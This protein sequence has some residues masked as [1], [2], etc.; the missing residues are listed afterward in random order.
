[1]LADEKRTLGNEY[2]TA[3]CHCKQELWRIA[4]SW[5]RYEALFC[6]TERVEILNA[7]GGHFWGSVQSILFDH[8]L[9]GICRLTDKH[10]MR[11]GKNV[12]VEMLGKLDTKQ[13]NKRLHQRIS[14]AKKKCSFARSWRDKRIAHND[15]LQMVGP[16]NLLGKATRR[17]VTSAIVSIHEVLRWVQQKHFDGDMMLYEMGDSSTLS[18]LSTLSDGVEC[19]KRQRELWQSG[20]WETPYNFDH[21][22]LRGNGSLKSRYTV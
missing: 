13:H 10:D 8:V 3:F 5:D 6:T 22:H 16:V 21:S 17:R 14:Q 9:L 12:S 19:R 20:V 15:Y 1:M 18:V 7:S 11:S 2:G 4:E